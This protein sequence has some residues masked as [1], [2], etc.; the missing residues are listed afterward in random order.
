[1]FAGL[2]L[3]RLSSSQMLS[4]MRKK[5]VS[6]LKVAATAFKTKQAKKTEM[7][8]RE[9]RPHVVAQCGV[10]YKVVQLGLSF[11]RVSSS[12]ILRYLVENSVSS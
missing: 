1:M 4:D 8:L 9:R 12:W 3:S 5:T 2:G 10:S 6:S 11:F 7:T